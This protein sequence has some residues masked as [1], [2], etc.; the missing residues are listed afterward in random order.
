[1]FPY[2]WDT[3]NDCLN[4]IPENA[5]SCFNFSVFTVKAVLKELVDKT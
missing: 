4:D 3:G 2:D 5:E 1:M